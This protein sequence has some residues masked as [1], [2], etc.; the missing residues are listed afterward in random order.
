MTSSPPP[1]APHF[2]GKTLTPESP[3]P[4]HISEPSNIPVLERQIDPLFNLMSTHMEHP[5]ALRDLTALDHDLARSFSDKDKA[6]VH[7]T[8]GDRDELVY[9]INHQDDHGKVPSK[10][11]SSVSL[12]KDDINSEQEQSNSSL[13]QI[14]SSS[15]ADQHSTSVAS[16]DI[17]SAPA[18]IHPTPTSSSIL[19]SGDS[20]Q[21]MLA[22]HDPSQDT[23]MIIDQAAPRVTTV[24]DDADQKS[25]PETKTGDNTDEDVAAG[26]VN[27]Q[28]LLDNISPASATAFSAT[29]PP[30]ATSTPS[31]E[32]ANVQ[33]S[34]SANAP[35]ATLP[36]PVGLPP[37]PPPQEKPA[38]HP[39]YMPGED[40]RSYHYPQIHLATAHANHSS[41]PS[42]SYRP[43]QIYAPSMTAS[44]APGT[45]SAPNG[46]PPPPMA[47]FQQPL[48]NHDQAQN[49]PNGQQF[50]Q[51]DVSGP[52]GNGSVMSVDSG[53]ELKWS[54]E[55]ERKYEDFLGKERIYVSEGLWD[56]FPP[57]SRLFVGKQ[58]YSWVYL[59]SHALI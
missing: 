27:Y 8:D 40:I 5:H 29:Y 28:T 11:N 58:S 43:S 25:D 13:N 54:P 15:L 35:S 39:N 7:N 42:N 36:A 6:H 59:L 23:S 10:D 45:S 19:P 53:S 16:L 50:R 17:L 20:S 44:A 21:H 49:S 24:V 55:L 4:V 22:I 57:G 32:T 46:L 52:N 34:S 2:R 3:R 12:G 30:H 31:T 51:P 41:Q 14:Q 1:E 33:A 38:I 47:T 37:R 18:Q 26:G 48:R 9:G 56:R